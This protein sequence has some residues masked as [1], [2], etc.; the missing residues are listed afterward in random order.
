MI[1]SFSTWPMVEYFYSEYEQQYF[2]SFDPLFLVIVL[3]A[4]SAYGFT[5]LVSTAKSDLR[6]PS[7]KKKVE[8]DY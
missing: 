3:M 6:R 7:S 5:R 8:D 2:A 4:A 1:L